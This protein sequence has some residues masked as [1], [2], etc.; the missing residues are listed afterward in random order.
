M[1]K[2][3]GNCRGTLDSRRSV[4]PQA[5]L[6]VSWNQG[7]APVASALFSFH[8]PQQDMHRFTALFAALLLFAPATHVR[9]EPGQSLTGKVTSAIDGDTYKVDRP[10][11]PVV[12]V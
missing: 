7:P 4:C 5:T 9:V 12:K 1:W 6:H 10:A 3:W 8:R 2:R 11:G